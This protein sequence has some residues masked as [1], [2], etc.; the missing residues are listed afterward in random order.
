[1]TRYTTQYGDVPTHLWPERGDDIE[2][3][4][5]AFVLAEGQSIPHPGSTK[6]LWYGPGLYV[7]EAKTGAM[8]HWEFDPPTDPD[9]LSTTPRL[10]EVFRVEAS[11]PGEVTFFDVVTVVE[12]RENVEVS[13]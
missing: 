13:A 7:F 11:V 8:G 5:G 4:Y 12:P 3:H 10:G 9:D 1:M 2:T 6:H